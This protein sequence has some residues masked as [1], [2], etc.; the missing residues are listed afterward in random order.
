M[1]FFV[2]PDMPPQAVPQEQVV[3]A[4]AP[5]SSASAVRKMTYG[6]C[7]LFYATEDD[8]GYIHDS[9]VNSLHP[10]TYMNG[11]LPS[12]LQAILA[13]PGIGGAAPGIN[14][15]WYVEW[16]DS[17]KV[18]ILQEPVHGKFVNMRNDQKRHDLQYL[19]D[20]DYV[21]KDRVD[22]LVEGKDDRGRPI[23]LTLKYFINVLPRKELHRIADKGIHTIAQTQKRLCGI[24][25]GVWTISAPP[26]LSNPGGLAAVSLATLLSGASQSLTFTTFPTI[27]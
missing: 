2:T 9:S 8:R 14:W 25:K 17:F 18:T 11:F 12:K 21:G 10:A 24:G 4:T 16:S 15:N 20:R 27:P 13:T 3:V 26:N 7:E 19:P 23:A 6:V 1:V 5:S 22:V